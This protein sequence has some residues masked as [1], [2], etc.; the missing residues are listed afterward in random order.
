[1]RRCIQKVKPDAVIHLGDYYSDF[2]DI[3]E[4]Y[5]QLIYY[6]VPGNCD[7]HRVSGEAE[8]KVPRLFGVGL[9]MTHGHRHGVKMSPFRLLA[10]ARAAKVQAVLYGHT[11]IPVCQQEE[12]GLWILNPGP[13]TWGGGAGLITTQDGQILRCDWLSAADVQ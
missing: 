2:L 1:M 5:P 8:I 11:H 3:Q 10:D 13:A 9:Y 6:A 7:L 12:D 4:E